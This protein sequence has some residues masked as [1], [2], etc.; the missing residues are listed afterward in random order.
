M[1]H[2][3]PARLTKLLAPAVTLSFASSAVAH[4][5][6]GDPGQAW[7]LAHYLGE[8]L[9]VVSA[10]VVLVAAGGAAAL[11]RRRRAATRSR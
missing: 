1:P 10:L 11:L 7:S 6:H 2:F 3:A 9:H 8:P 5:G 4:P